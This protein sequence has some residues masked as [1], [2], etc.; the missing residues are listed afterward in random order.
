MDTTATHH[1]PSSQAKPSSSTATTTGG[2]GSSSSSSKSACIQHPRPG[3]QRRVRQYLPEELHL[4]LNRRERAPKSQCLLPPATRTRTCIYA[5]LIR[6]W[7][8]C[9]GILLAPA[10]FD[11]QQCR[12]LPQPHTTSSALAPGRGGAGRR[13]GLRLGGVKQRKEALPY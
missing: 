9:R 11:R 8:A 4:T 1:H 6:L 10:C 2:S 13:E 12:Q 3:H 5:R 7:H